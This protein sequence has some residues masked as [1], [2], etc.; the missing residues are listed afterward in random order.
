MSETSKFLNVR[1]FGAKGSDFT[2]KINATAGSNI[3][4][5]D[6]IGDFE[7]GDE[8]VVTK[9][10]INFPIKVLFERRDISPVNKRKWI[11]NQPIGDRIE[12][13]GYDG[14]QGDRVVY[15]L[16][17][18][19][20]N[21]GKFRWSKD[22]SRTWHED[23]EITD[24]WIDIELGIHVKI[25]DFKERSYGCTAVYVCDNKMVALI[26][27][28]EG[29]KIYLSETANITTDGEIMHSDTYAIQK[30]VDA[31]IAENK[32]VFLPNGKY[33][34]AYS[35]TI[36]GASSI[37]FEG[38]SSENTIIDNCFGHIGIEKEG[39]SCFVIK[40]N[41]EVILKNLFMIGNLGFA[42]RD[43]AG[44]LPVKGG[45]SVWGFYFMK[46][47]A[48]CIMNNESVYIENCHARRMSAEC[49]YAQSN[50]RE[51]H[52]V[53]EEYRTS[54][55]YNRC[56]VED[57]ARNAFNN[58]DHA[59]LTTL[60]YCRVIDVGGCS[61]EGAS[62]FVKIHGCY[63]RNGGSIAL[64]NCRQRVDAFNILG[65]GQH[66]ITD[67]YFE[68]GVCYGV[69]MI[70]VGSTASQIIIKNNNFINFNGNGIWF[71]G[72]C[73][74]TDTPCENI[75]IGGNIFDMTASVSE[76][77]PRY[78]IKLTSNFANVS[79][80]QIYVRGDTDENLTGIIISDDA[81][82]ISVHDNTIAGA[83]IGI[84]SED[85]VGNVGAVSGDSSFFRENPR[86]G[87][88]DKK[89]MLLRRLSDLYRGWH[90]L[91]EDGTESE[92]EIF[93]W[94][95]TEFKLTSPRKMTVGEKFIIY[96]PKAVPWS[97]HHNIIDNCTKALVLDTNTGK[98]AFSKDNITN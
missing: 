84:I 16:D 29:N 56:T 15:F 90:L 82:R 8:V 95:T 50:D 10:F 19:P 74:P 79:D 93:D 75:I 4:T 57:C 38:E 54:I 55:T 44:C 39:G 12:F 48:A 60:L 22:F 25:G 41:K 40:D 67:N 81:A 64:G 18:A 37:T 92:I 83:G 80:N 70:R 66:I 68:N 31:A 32:S 45:D 30:A 13:D 52:P 26:E 94:Q 7:V 72:E 36:A 49:F 43:I 42:D 5:V 27:K 91:W 28:I 65:T 17:F 23:I 47:N 86:A 73:G 59:E 1:D 98:R 61:W 62:R 20:D 96:N 51:R 63:F 3:I 77:I 53:P 21:Q 78:A 2:T 76:S 6:S 46:T 69:S 71:M 89:P 33:R 11:H 9:C 85:A 34:L 24:G 58:N 97:I 14:S 35:V 87:F 88:G